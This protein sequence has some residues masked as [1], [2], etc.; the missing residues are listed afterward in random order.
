M[1]TKDD[2]KMI[3]IVGLG[4]PGA[5]YINT[6]HNIGF[7]AVDLISNRY[8]FIWAH[9]PKFNAYIATGE[10]DLGKV[11]LCKPDTFMNLS[12]RAVQAIASFYKIPLDKIIVIHDDID[13]PPAKIKHKIGGGAGGHNGLKSLDNIIG[14]NYQRVRI[15]VGRPNN[16][17]YN[18]SDYV[19]GKF[20]QDEEKLMSEKLELLIDNLKL[21]AK[22][23]FEK[24][25]SSVC[26]SK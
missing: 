11:I 3:L 23:D 18:V 6:R 16:K 20:T 13:L 1:A 25:R 7:I 2:L 12:G 9:K 14:P 22:N 24:F 10:C 26:E 15:G 19:L 17:E 4:N 8:N 5:N 21:L